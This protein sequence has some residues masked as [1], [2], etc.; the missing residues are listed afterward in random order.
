MEK[1]KSRKTVSVFEDFGPEEVTALKNLGLERRT[2]ENEFWKENVLV[3]KYK[4][5]TFTVFDLN[6]KKFSIVKTFEEALKLM[7]G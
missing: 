6:K 7:K 3:A 5:H 1:K 2:G 4:N